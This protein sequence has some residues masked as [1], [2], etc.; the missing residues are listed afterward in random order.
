VVH[1]FEE[2]QD[3]IV[4]DAMIQRHEFAWELACKTIK[5]YLEYAGYDFTPSPRSVIKQAFQQEIIKDD[6]SWL[7]SLDYRYHM[8]HTYN[9]L[10]A[11]ELASKIPHQFLPMFQELL[12][13]LQELYEES[14]SN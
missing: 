14:I 7:T 13:K 10:K 8:A 11:E 1:V 3:N 4:Q 12:I 9:Q 6:V 5:E 2:K